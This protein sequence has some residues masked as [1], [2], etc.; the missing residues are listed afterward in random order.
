MRS[1]QSI[2]PGGP[3]S[4]E[5]REVPVP[6]PGAGEVLVKVMACALNF[7]DSLIIEDRYQYKPERPFAP[8]AELAGIVEAVGSQVTG[9]VAGDRVFAMPGWGGL[10]EQVVLD[11]HKCFL[12]PD[13]VPFDQ[14]AALIMTYG[15]AYHA[16]VQRAQVQAGETVLV[17]GAAGG[18]GLAAIEIAKARGAR[19]V[20]AASSEAKL[21]VACEHGA[22]A[23]VVY[24]RGRIEGDGRRAL[25][26]SLKAACGGKGADV[27]VDCVGGDL[28]EAAL[29]SLAWK[30][31]LLVIGFP[32]GISTLATNLLLLKGA[33]AIGVF[34]GTFT[35]LEG[36]Q[37]R[38]N[39]AALLELYRSGHIRP[40]IARR[41]PLEQGGAAIAAMLEIGACGKIIV[42]VM[43]RDEA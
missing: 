15:T 34:Y 19:V 12:L 16:L 25:V 40:H 5:L 1:L 23:A 24:P 9:L 20:A 38:A 29:R 32:A 35:E 14:G 42:D 37:D 13:D 26:G 31:R 4:L 17:T 7:P 30:G 41:F 43:A 28:T 3:D 39:M 10:S 11:A 22:D 2:L 6:V 33:S 18:V 8:G 21:E 36:D 27:V